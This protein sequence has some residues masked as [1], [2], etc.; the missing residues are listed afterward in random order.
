MIFQGTKRGRVTRL[1]AVLFTLGAAVAHA[2]MSPG[3]LARAH[4]D[5]DG[6]LKCS[7]C[8]EF[9]TRNA[10][11]KCLECHGEVR[12]RLEE[13]K[14]YHAKVV[15]GT[16]TQASADCARCH[17]EHNGR[18]HQLVRWRTPKES[19]DHA[20]EAGWPLEGKH[21]RAKCEQCHAAKNISQEDRAVLKRA[22]LSKTYLGLNE[23]CANCHRDEHHGDLGAD[24]AKC[25]TLEAWKP[26]TGFTHDRSVFQLTGGHQRVP[27]EKCHQRPTFAGAYVKYKN[28]GF[29]ETCKACHKDPH[30]GS[31]AADC[32]KCHTTENWKQ[33]RQAGGFDHG[34]TKYPLAGRHA[35][36]QCRKCHK[37][38][39]FRVALTHERC[40]DCHQDKHKGQFAARDGGECAPC[41]TETG[42][43]PARFAVKEH[44]ATRYP[45]AGLHVKVECAKCHQGKGEAANYHP[46]FG[47]CRDCHKDR[48]AGQ[49]AALP[50]E[51]RCERC[52]VETG[53]KAVR[54]ALAEHRRSRFALGGAHAA[55]PCA[56]CHRQAAAV[57]A[58]RFRFP[59]TACVDC[60]EDPHRPVS[61][62]V[63]VT[64]VKQ[65]C[66][67]CHTVR[68]WKETGPF[69]HNSTQFP[70]LGRHRSAA[71]TGC[72]KP[73]VLGSRTLVSFR[74][75]T[76]QCGAC[77]ADVHDGQFQGMA[78]SQPD[79]VR[80]HTVS[81][82]RPTEFDHKK[83][84]TFSLAGAHERVPCRMCHANRGPASGRAVIAYKG[85]PRNCQECH[86]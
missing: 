37:S 16:G 28:F 50:H 18:K 82:W 24:C 38:E 20:K 62:L 48:H 47:S 21:A 81:N 31:F 27:C 13:K 42:W 34:K 76:T 15:R 56:E 36:V 7:S 35:Q 23:K 63:R 65:A 85:T 39:N 55:V 33:V 71:C 79:C 40:L 2:Q 17:A 44:A 77:H 73:A 69:D 54:F 1:A 12:R 75:T 67:S 45:L 68:S 72:H 8:H 57:E 80:C 53:W 61:G 3:E 6:P 60:H 30:G 5:L 46:G 19:F 70:L 32:E 14:G 22:D 78:G 84:S 4:A 11:L 59:S 74:G 9:G 49:F 43:K 25:H 64:V 51:D 66:D 26:A 83:H 58:R 86:R 52:H 10:H 41:H 29:F